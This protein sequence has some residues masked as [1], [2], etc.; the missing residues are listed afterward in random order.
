MP[1]VFII[2][3]EFEKRDKEISNL[4]QIEWSK[5]DEKKFQ[6]EFMSIK[7]DEIINVELNDPDYSFIS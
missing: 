5:F 1:Q 3:D 6:N 2:S 7:W 4:S